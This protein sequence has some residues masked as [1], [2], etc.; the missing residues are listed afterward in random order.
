M[1]IPTFTLALLPVLRLVTDSDAEDLIVIDDHLI[2][3]SP[4]GMWRSEPT[5]HLY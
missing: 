5:H 3:A 2:R 4:W 1:R